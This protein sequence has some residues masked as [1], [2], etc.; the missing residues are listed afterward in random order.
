MEST[1]GGENMDI[2]GEVSNEVSDG[3]S[4]SETI[5]REAGQEKEA[6]TSEESSGK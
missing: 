5:C 3:V 6:Q 2:E 4:T 1:A